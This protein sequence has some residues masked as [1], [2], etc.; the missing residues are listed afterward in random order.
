MLT[1][2]RIIVPTAGTPFVGAPED[3]RTAEPLTGSVA[4]SGLAP[5]VPSG[6][7]SYLVDETFESFAAG[8]TRLAGQTFNDVIIY[9]QPAT[10]VDDPQYVYSGTKAL[11]C[12]NPSGGED[13]GARVNYAAAGEGD[14]VWMQ[15][16]IKFE[17]GFSFI[18]SGPPAMKTFAAG[19]EGSSSSRMWTSINPFSGAEAP[20]SPYTNPDT[21]N[22]F[23]YQLTNGIQFLSEVDSSNYESFWLGTE[24]NSAS[25]SGRIRP[26]TDEWILFETYVKVSAT[27]GNGVWRCW[28][29]IPSLGISE[30]MIFEDTQNQTISSGGNVHNHL[31]LFGFHNGGA[32]ATQSAYIDSIRITKTQPSRQDVWGNYLIGLS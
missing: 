9:G 18:V 20:G 11:R 6:S 26:P 29:T 5:F 24:L 2:I 12:T 3:N 4:L 22:E 21:G 32:P 25:P 19:Q 16:W 10:I 23:D 31:F 15:A 1:D 14:E 7:G 28:Q 27:D 30:K 17:A 13:W 8:T